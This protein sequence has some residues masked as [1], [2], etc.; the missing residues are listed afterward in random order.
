MEM[1]ALRAEGKGAGLAAAFVRVATWPLAR[2]VHDHGKRAMTDVLRQLA[3]CR[4][5][6]CSLHGVDALM[7]E[8]G[9]STP[10]SCRL[11]SDMT[12]Y[13]AGDPR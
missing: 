9:Q 11:L 4:K 10:V 6:P 2:I 13:E 1:E 3:A 12:T 5:E 8:C 7:I